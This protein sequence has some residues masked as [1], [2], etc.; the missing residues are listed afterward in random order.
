MSLQKDDNSYKKI[1]EN[2]LIVT[3]KP[4]IFTVTD[5]RER[6]KSS[7]DS[8]QGSEHGSPMIR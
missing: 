4:T 3:Q 2:L 6:S 7:G 1:G 8:S 5:K